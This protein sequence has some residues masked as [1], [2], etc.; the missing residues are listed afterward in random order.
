L[1]TGKVEAHLKDGVLSLRVPKAEQAKP[2]S[3]K[4]VSR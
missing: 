3:I 1:D 2:K 4:I